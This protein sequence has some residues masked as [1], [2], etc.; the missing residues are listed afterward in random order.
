MSVGDHF[1]LFDQPKH[2]KS[3]EK[4]R[5][6]KLIKKKM[7]HT[8]RFISSSVVLNHE[9]IHIVGTWMFQARGVIMTLTC[10]NQFKVE[11]I[12]FITTG[13]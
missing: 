3:I 1:D 8:V 7:N 12:C 11:D 9:K 6:N 10:D 4:Y 5:V 13:C 2:K